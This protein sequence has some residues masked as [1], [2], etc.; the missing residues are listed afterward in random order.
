MIHRHT[1]GLVPHV[2]DI[3][4]NIGEQFPLNGHHPA[5]GVGVPWIGIVETYV[6]TQECTQAL[7]GTSGPL[8]TGRERI[9]KSSG[10]REEAI[11][12]SHQRCGLAEA[13]RVVADDS[14]GEVVD[15]DAA[16]DNGFVSEEPGRPG[17]PDAWR[18]VIF[19]S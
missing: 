8:D 2:A 6:F 4:Q 15:T 14:E 11:E 10:R 16:A 9:G 12:R 5:G 1:Y 3:E 19:R 7:T 13:R 17:E 18:E